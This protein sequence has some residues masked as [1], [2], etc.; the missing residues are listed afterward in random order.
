MRKRIYLRPMVLVIP[1]D[2]EN[3]CLVNSGTTSGYVPGMNW[4][5]GGGSTS[6]T[7]P[8]MG[9]EYENGNTSATVPGMSWEEY[10]KP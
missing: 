1:L 7:V 2:G 10:E 9:W 3:V 8:G 4:E 6:G 5:N